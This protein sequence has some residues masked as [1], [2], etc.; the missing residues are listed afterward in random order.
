MHASQMRGK[1]FCEGGEG[2]NWGTLII[3]EALSHLANEEGKCEMSLMNRI[4]A[5]IMLKD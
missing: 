3:F 2:G 4:D 1:W 5:K